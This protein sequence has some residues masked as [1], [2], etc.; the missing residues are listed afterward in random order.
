[1]ATEHIFL[2]GKAKWAKVWKPDQEYDKYSI[3]LYMDDE[4]FAIYDDSGMKLKLREDE[5]GKYIRFSRPASKVINGE[6]TEFKRPKIVNADNEEIEETVLIGNGSDVT[7]RVEVYDTKAHGKG[8]R[9][10]AVRIDNLVAYEPKNSS[11]DLED[12]PF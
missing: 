8:H 11:S 2:S 10:N 1:M 3:D 7:V 9:L 5:D 6:L 12:L 4:N